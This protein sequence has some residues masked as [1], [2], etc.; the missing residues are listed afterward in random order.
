MFCLGDGGA[1][2]IRFGRLSSTSV[3]RHVDLRSPIVL[4]ARARALGTAGASEGD[5]I[6]GPL[7][8]D[9]GLQVILL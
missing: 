7:V 2:M 3:R 5:G 8:S 9:K 6:D 4:A 1:D